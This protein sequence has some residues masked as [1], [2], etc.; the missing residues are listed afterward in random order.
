MVPALKEQMS[1]SDDA[2]GAALMGGALGGVVAMYFA[3]RVLERLKHHT[4]PVLIIVMALVLQLPGFVTSAQMFFPMMIAFGIALA[5]VDVCANIRLSH[6]EEQHGTH[7]MSVNHAVFSLGFGSAA[8]TISKLRL[9]G[10]DVWEVFGLIGAVILVLSIFA[11]DHDWAAA[12]EQ[13]A[14]GTTQKL[15]RLLVC[16]TGIM[17]FASFIGE[18]ATEAWSAIFIERELGATPGAGSLGPA[19]LGFVMFVARLCAQAIV[20]HLGEKRLLIGSGILG[21]IGALVL[22][23]AQGQSV[24]LI[25]I[26]IIAIGVAAVVPTASALLGKSVQRAQRAD[27]LSKAWM[28]GMSGYFIGPSM[29]GF[30]SETWG[31]RMAFVC[32]A[33]LVLLVVPAVLVFQKR[34][35]AR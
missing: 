16:L 22:A 18:N 20:E 10:Y 29:M 25:G 15:P 7:L 5:G 19:M 21:A 32:V 6:L 2:L 30:V 8:F 27:A 24:A 13:A 28:L 23:S 9:A 35:S 31:L 14:D 33:V 34:A 26:G 17:L 4:L 11:R 12:D 1:A 3:P